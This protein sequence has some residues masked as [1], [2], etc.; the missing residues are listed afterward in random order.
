MIVRDLIPKYADA[1]IHAPAIRINTH[2]TAVLPPKSSRATGI[3]NIA[4]PTPN[5]PIC[6]KLV[7]AEEI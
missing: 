5:H 2:S 1:V 7:S 4:I 3:A 6:V